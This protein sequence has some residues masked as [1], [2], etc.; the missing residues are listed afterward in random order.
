[1]GRGRRASALLVAIL[2][3]GASAPSG[4][5]KVVASREGFRPSSLSV[6]KGETLRLLLSTADE[7]H[8]FALDALRV[9]KR[10]VP[11]KTTIVDVTPE[12]AGSFPF[13][14]CLEEGPRA[15]RGEL[16]VTE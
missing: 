5:V 15:I 14:C 6:R 13:H 8:C 3:L 10:I 9:E 16:R 4:E 12:K 1:V 11:G 2:A 7:E